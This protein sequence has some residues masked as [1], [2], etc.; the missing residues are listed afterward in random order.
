MAFE[1]IEDLG[2]GIA[3]VVLEDGSCFETN[4]NMI[5]VKGSSFS[6][7]KEFDVFCKAYLA[8]IPSSRQTL[9]MEKSSPINWDPNRNLVF[10][11][12]GKD[13]ARIYLGVEE[14]KLK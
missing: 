8:Q 3:R 14:S 5:S 6:E 12:P 11:L 2:S 4:F 10:Y 7:V 9:R 13:V 1:D